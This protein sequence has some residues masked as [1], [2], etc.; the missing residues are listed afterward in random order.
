VNRGMFTRVILLAVAAGTLPL[1]VQYAYLFLSRSNNWRF[2]SLDLLV[3]GLAIAI[4]IAFIWRMPMPVI[5]RA[6]TAAIY[7]PAS[8]VLIVQFTLRFVCRAFHDCL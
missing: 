2:V 6:A 4:G 7:V 1:A 3:F 5:F 8:M